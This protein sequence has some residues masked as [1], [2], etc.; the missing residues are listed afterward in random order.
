[1]LNYLFIMRACSENFTMGVIDVKL[2]SLRYV[3]YSGSRLSIRF[4]V[5]R[6][7]CLFSMFVAF[8]TIAGI[9]TAMILLVTAVFAKM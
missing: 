4:T 6:R 2:C 7:K 1:M 3:D 5:W 9:V 8:V